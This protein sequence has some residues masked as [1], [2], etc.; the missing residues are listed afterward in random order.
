MAIEII[1][2]LILGA[3]FAALAGSFH[4]LLRL[5]PSEPDATQFMMIACF[6]GL[7][8]CDRH[9]REGND[10]LMTALTALILA[11]AALLAWWIARRRARQARVGPSAVNTPQPRL[12]AEGPGREN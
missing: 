2:L 12:I 7:L 9:L 5:R 8:L 11:Q 6:F 1:S 10:P 4:Y 3:A